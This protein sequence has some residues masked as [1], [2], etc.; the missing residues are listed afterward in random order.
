MSI[1]SLAIFLPQY[2]R[3]ASFETPEIIPHDQFNFGTVKNAQFQ[4]AFG[5]IRRNAHGSTKLLHG[6]A[7][8]EDIRFTFRTLKD[9]KLLSTKL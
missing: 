4:G 9:A 8:F 7:N 2:S 6:I 3:V 1:T 5:K